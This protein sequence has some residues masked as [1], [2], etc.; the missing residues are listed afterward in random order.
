MSQWLL[1]VIYRVFQAEIEWY[2]WK[3]LSKLPS[4]LEIEI[5]FTKNPYIYLHKHRLHAATKSFQKSNVHFCSCL[6]TLNHTLD[7][8]DYL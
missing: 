4:F 6:V 3:K 8:G 2:I 5:Y 1:H 7:I